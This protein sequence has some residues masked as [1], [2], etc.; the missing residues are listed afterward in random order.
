M[1]ATV[2]LIPAAFGFAIWNAYRK[3]RARGESEEPAERAH[4]R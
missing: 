2:T 3:A 1:L 4:R